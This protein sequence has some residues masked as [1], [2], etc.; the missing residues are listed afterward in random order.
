MHQCL[1]YHR[2]CNTLSV[3]RQIGRI[4]LAMHHLGRLRHVVQEDHQL[5][6]CSARTSP[7]FAQFAG[8]E[9]TRLHRGRRRLLSDTSRGATHLA[10]ALA[11]VSFSRAGAFQLWL[12]AA[13][14]ATSCLSMHICVESSR[15]IGYRD[16]RM[17]PGVHVRAI[18][19]ASVVWLCM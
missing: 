14:S 10:C 6:L 11:G 19:A 9:C 15:H 5:C 1:G 13:A 16:Q 2:H 4:L 3:H 17:Q 8:A 7:S 18:R 12:Q